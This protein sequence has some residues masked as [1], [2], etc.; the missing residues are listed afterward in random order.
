MT[1]T[2]HIACGPTAAHLVHRLL[3]LALVPVA[4]MLCIFWYLAWHGGS[5]EA[6][7]E[8]SPS[9]SCSLT[10]EDDEYDEERAEEE[11]EGEEGAEYDSDS[12]DD[13]QTATI[14]HWWRETLGPLGETLGGVEMSREPSWDGSS[15]AP[16]PSPAPPSPAVVR[17][18][19]DGLLDW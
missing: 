14:Q 17:R 8:T 12:D 9:C 16:S 15:Y 1:H 7:P 19:E 3:A 10:L 2:S 11:E 4:P 6:S 18:T 13:S 5:K